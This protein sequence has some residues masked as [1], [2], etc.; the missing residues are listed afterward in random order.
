MCSR[1]AQACWLSCTRL[2][3]AGPGCPAWHGL[4]AA[5]QPRHG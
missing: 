1:A 3:I 5:A 2:D 4:G